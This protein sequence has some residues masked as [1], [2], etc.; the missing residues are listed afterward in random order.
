MYN[1]SNALNLSS[2]IRAPSIV[3]FAHSCMTAHCPKIQ[4]WPS[5][6]RQC[7]TAS[8][9]ILES[10]ICCGRRRW[11][12]GAVLRTLQSG[13]GRHEL[14]PLTTFRQPQG[15]LEQPATALPVQ[16]SK[17]EWRQGRCEFGTVGNSSAR[18]LL[19]TFNVK[20]VNINY[21]EKWQQY[22]CHLVMLQWCS[23]SCNQLWLKMGLA[24]LVVNTGYSLTIRGCAESIAFRIVATLYRSFC[25]ISI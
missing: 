6:S 14:F 3:N 4:S 8:E 17:T 19:L 25:S 22:W 12:A 5:L 18:H 7:K 20:A 13:Q 10:I 15:G 23:V 11:L 1:C 9:C 16:D 2:T 24:K 21:A